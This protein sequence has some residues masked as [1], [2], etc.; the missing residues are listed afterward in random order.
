M[1]TFSELHVFRHKVQRVRCTYKKHSYPVLV[2]HA[3]NPLN[4]LI[5]ESANQQLVVKTTELFQRHFG[6]RVTVSLGHGDLGCFHYLH[7]EYHLRKTSHAK[8]SFKNRKF[9]GTRPLLEITVNPG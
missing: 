7:P 2:I 6:P 9:Y 1:E 3:S 8:I 5:A 4:P